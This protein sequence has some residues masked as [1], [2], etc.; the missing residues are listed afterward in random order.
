MKTLKT[1]FISMVL[2]AALSMG[3]SACRT[4]FLKPEK[5]KKEQQKQRSSTAKKKRSEFRKKH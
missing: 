4:S 1:K 3:F 2:I 5:N